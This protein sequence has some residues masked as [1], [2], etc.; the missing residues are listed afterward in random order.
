MKSS[1]FTLFL[2]AAPIACQGIKHP[3][4]LHTEDDFSRIK[5]L[6]DSKKEPFATGWQ[7]LV[8]RADVNWEPRVTDVICRGQTDWCTDNIANFFR[9]VHA[10]YTNAI[11]WKVTG[12]TAHANTAARIIDAWSEKAPPIQ[13]SA[14]RYLAAGI[15]GYQLA[16]AAEILRG[17]EGWNGLQRISDYLASEF[18]GNNHRF[19]TEHNDAPINNYWANWDLCNLASVYAIGVLSDNQT[20]MNEAIDYFKNGGGMGA[21]ENALWF[22]HKEENTGKPLAQCQ[23]SGRDQGHTLMDMGLLGVVAQQGYNQG[24]D[25]F[26]YLD[27]RILAGA[28]YTF[29]Y[30]TD[31]DVPFE[32]Y[33]NSRHGTHTVIDPRQRGQERPVAELLHAH[34]TSVKGLDASWTAEYRDK[35]VDAAGGAERGGGDYGPNSGGYDQ[36]GFGTILFRRD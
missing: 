24:E 2:G 14:D 7:K 10:A 34:Y 27:N 33:Y 21:I 9:D 26:A 31:H 23:E 8:N 1:L 4:L 15:Q 12:D 3:G 17:Y 11:Y 6:V 16:N 29:K 13:G 20:M 28:E 18:Y 22:V 30:N 32:P 36:L 35:V 25:L 5:S 19:L